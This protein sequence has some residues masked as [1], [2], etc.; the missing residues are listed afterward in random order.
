M[1][2]D[3][4]RVTEAT[5]LAAIFSGLPSTLDA[6]VRRGGV[7]AAAAYV[8]DTTRAIGT[9]VAPGRP[10][11]ARGALVH[12]G[13]SAVC[14]EGLARALPRD[15]S[16]ATGAAAGLAIGVVNVAIIGRLFPAIRALPLLPQLADNVAFGAVVASV[17][18]RPGALR[19]RRG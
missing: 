7:R 2:R 15:P 6:L 8:Y 4:R 5:L 12:L 17:L 18:D 14:A 11:F 9:L 3:R 16:L 19:A 13:I 10:G 1:R